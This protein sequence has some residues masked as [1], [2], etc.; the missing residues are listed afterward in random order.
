MKRKEILVLLGEVLGSRAVYSVASLVITITMLSG[1][2]IILRNDIRDI[3]NYVQSVV[4][5]D[6]N[7]K[8]IHSQVRGSENVIRG[9]IDVEAVLAKEDKKT[10]TTST[11]NNISGGY[12]NYTPTQTITDDYNNKPSNGLNNS[13]SGETTIANNNNSSNNNSN[14]NSTNEVNNNN[15]NSDEDK[16]EDVLDRSS[17]NGKDVMVSEG[18]PFNPMNALQLAATDINGKNITNKIVIT[19]NNVDTYKPGL[20]TVKANVTLSNENTLEKEFLVRVEPTILNLAVNDLKISKDV[21]EKNEHFNLTFAVKSSKSYLEVASVNINNEDYV[22]NKTSSSSFFRTSNKYEVDLVAPSK[23]GTEK[24]EIKSVTMSDGTIVD[25]NK[26]VNVEVLREEPKI[27]DGVIKNVSNENK[28][29][30]LEYNLQDVDNAIE[31]AILYLYNENNII[32]QREE[33]EKNNKSY[34]DLNINENGQ[35]KVEIKGY[36]KDN[37]EAISE[38]YKEKELFTQNI[39]VNKF[40]NDNVISNDE[41]LLLASIEDNE[42]YNNYNLET[43]SFDGEKEINSKL[44]ESEKNILES[45]VMRNSYLNITGSDE[46][47][48][49]HEISITG[50]VEDGN[51]NTKPNTLNVTVPTVASFT[52]NKNKMF[53]GTQIRIQ[54]NGTQDIDVFAYE[55]KDPTQSSG[56]I[57]KK[58]S[59]LQ[60]ADKTNIVALRLE[61]D[62]GVAHFASDPG[63]N[64]GVYANEEHTGVAND[65]GVKIA[66]IL[67]GDS[68][69]L[70]LRGDINENSPIVDKPESDTFTLRLKIKKSEKN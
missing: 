70:R 12:D 51:G 18:E 65:D 34:I 63:S 16:K 33:L 10:E 22:V 52:V 27:T 47:E 32:I 56:I 21:L 68:Y 17:F 37:V 29:I 62:F 26:S 58:K 61:G 8:E 55:F 11:A 3:K 14:N 41:K 15:N 6:P 44:H 59:D 19:E 1:I 20:Y 38:L 39:D 45:K 67:K 48:H 24:I 64:R 42:G 23:A 49:K 30:F 31:N 36:Y 69:D 66:N 25:I 5:G 2:T 28:N 9:N 60:S 40:N 43:S 4:D 50:N 54:N 46:I 13:N 35:Y 53:L 7:Y 57:V